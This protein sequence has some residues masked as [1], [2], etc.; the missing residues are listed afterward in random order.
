MIF[1]S[2]LIDEDEGDDLMVGLVLL[3]L[4]LHKDVA[5]K[6]GSTFHSDW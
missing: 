6:N 5:S 4:L 3:K 2:L 1:H